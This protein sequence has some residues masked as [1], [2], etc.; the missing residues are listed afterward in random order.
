MMS[1]SLTANPRRTRW[2]D[3]P[4]LVSQILFDILNSFTSIVLK[5]VQSWRCLDPFPT[6]FPKNVHRDG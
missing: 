4:L 6:S 1:T 3:N 5:G 2:S